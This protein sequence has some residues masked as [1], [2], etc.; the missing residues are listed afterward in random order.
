MPIWVKLPDITV[1]MDMPSTY[2]S[3]AVS[4]ITVGWWMAV[5]ALLLDLIFLTLECTSFHEDAIS[6]GL[7]LDGLLG[8]FATYNGMVHAYAFDVSPSSLSRMVIFC[9]LQ[10]LSFIF[11]RVGAL[12]GRL[13]VSWMTADPHIWQSHTGFA[14]SVALASFNLLYIYCVLPESLEQPPRPLE[15]QSCPLS[16]RC[17]HVHLDDG[18][19]LENLFWESHELFLGSGG[20][21][22]DVHYGEWIF[23]G[24]AK[25]AAIAHPESPE[26]RNMARSPSG[27]VYGDTEKSGR[28]LSKAVTQYSILAAACCV[29]GILVFGGPRPSPLYALFF[30]LYYPLSAGALPALYALAASYFV[31][32][33]RTAEIGAL[34]GGLSIWSVLGE[35]ISYGYLGDGISPYTLM[36]QLEWA[37]FFLVISLLLLVPDG[38]PTLAED[39]VEQNEGEGRP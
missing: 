4:F 21:N 22:G 10:A 39:D 17:I 31:A 32:L 20:E 3:I 7:I 8:G 35:Y 33:G 23:F 37:G 24:P 11:F 26:P 9:V 25:M 28:L 1:W 27:R 29:L 36:Y 18:G 38:P 30:F 16:M 19:H 6:M 15:I 14:L 34:F 2:A 13:T 5:G 12:F